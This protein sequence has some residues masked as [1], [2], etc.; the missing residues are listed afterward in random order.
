MRIIRRAGLKAAVVRINTRREVVVAIPARLPPTAVLDLAR[1]VLSDGEYEQLCT[2]VRP[3]PD[4]T[5][6]RRTPPARG[7]PSGGRPGSGPQ[8]PSR[9]QGT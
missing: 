8:G 4:G 2:E 7:A 5:A 9:Y 3:G 6:A 1:L